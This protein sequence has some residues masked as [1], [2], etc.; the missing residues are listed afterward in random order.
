MKKLL[1]TICLIFSIVMIYAQEEPIHV[2][3]LGAHPDDCDGDAGHYAKGGGELAKLRI[4]EAEAARKRFGVEYMV[5]G[6]NRKR[7]GV[8]LQ[9]GNQYPGHFVEADNPFQNHFI[10]MQKKLVLFL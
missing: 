7:K 8:K 9:S 10:N 4:A 3:V 1:F 6:K 2:I 5:M